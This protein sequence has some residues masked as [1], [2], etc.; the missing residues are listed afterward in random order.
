MVEREHLAGAAEARLHLVDAEERPVA[1]AELLGALQVAGRRQVDALAL[2]R[3]DQEEGDVLPPELGLERVEVAELDRVEAGQELAEPL[4][5]LRAPV[6]RERAERQPVEAVVRE[7]DAGAP[8]RS[9]RVF[10]RRL[11]GLGPGAREDDAAERGRE[12]LEQR[13]RQ[14]ARVRRDAELRGERQVGRERVGQRGPHGGV[15]AADVEHPEP[16][17]EVEVA[18]ARVVDEVGAFAAH[19]GPVEAD[20]AQ[21]AHELR[22]HVALVERDGVREGSPV[23]DLG[24]ARRANEHL[25]RKLA[26][27]PPGASPT[28]RARP[29]VSLPALERLY[30]PAPRRPLRRRRT[31]SGVRPTPR[32]PFRRRPRP[33]RGR[34]TTRPPPAGREPAPPA[35]CR[36]SGKHSAGHRA[37]QARAGQAKRAKRKRVGRE[38]FE[39][40]TLGLRV[41][42]S[43][44]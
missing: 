10:E 14:P 27:Q 32:L 12:A 28:H 26:P 16:A 33:A 30:D 20:R 25:A 42:C 2:D 31:P 17:D 9:P 38:G 6:R 22:V 40:S 1:P 36:A 4:A 7:D 29:H 43:T 34:H 11:D 18:A 35:R 21:H 44:S 13:A 41:P 8:R 15:R 37:P 5:E 39:P 3:L 24:G 19:P 23:D